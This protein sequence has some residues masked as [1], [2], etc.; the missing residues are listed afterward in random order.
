[1]QPITAHPIRWLVAILALTSLSLGIAATSSHADTP[2]CNL[3]EHSLATGPSDVI[4]GGTE[5]TLTLEC[6]GN[7]SVTRVVKATV[8]STT[9]FSS[10][11]SKST[12]GYLLET[13]E[14][15]LP[16]L[17]AVPTVCLSID[18]GDSA[19]TDDEVCVPPA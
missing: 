13:E 12:N 19:T 16:A 18:D 14:I 8:D 3:G 2:N 4:L 9:Y 15:H 1:M 10:I 5:I 7:G 6:K 17:P 11:T